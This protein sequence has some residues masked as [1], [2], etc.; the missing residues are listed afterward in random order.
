MMGLGA[1]VILLLS[2]AVLAAIAV[3]PWLVADPIAYLPRN[4]A[5]PSVPAIVPAVPALDQPPIERY[6]AIVG[7]PL[8]TATRRPPP[9]AATAV[10]EDSLIL[11]RYALT[12]VVV[13]PT[14][15]V[16]FVTERG[17]GKTLTVARGETLGNW[18][19]VA[20]ER[21]RIILESGDQRREILVGE[22]VSVQEKGD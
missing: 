14:M 7:R 19:L 6:A 4:G 16:V 11:G 8:F 17:S 21:D 12:G 18:V 9:P 22:K 13:T 1:K 15:R 20:V 10:P 2:G 5:P 3:A